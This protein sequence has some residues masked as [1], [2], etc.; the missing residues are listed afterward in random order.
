MYKLYSRQVF[1]TKENGQ[2]DAVWVR[3][4]DN[5]E[6]GAKEAAE[7]KWLAMYGETIKVTFVNPV[8]WETVIA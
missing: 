1:F 5:T 2:E 7:Q 4:R 3:T 6:S 8:E